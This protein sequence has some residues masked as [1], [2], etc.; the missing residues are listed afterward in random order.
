MYTMP[1]E[2]FSSYIH[3]NGQETLHDRISSSN[4]CECFIVSAFIYSDAF[5]YMGV[6]T[7]LGATE[8]IHALWLSGFS[9]D[10]DIHTIRTETITD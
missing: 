5:M 2:T 6:S 9:K 3:A 8:Y 7:Q 10:K 4:R 1:L